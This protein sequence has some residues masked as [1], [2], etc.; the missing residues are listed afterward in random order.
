MRPRFLNSRLLLHRQIL[1]LYVTRRITDTF[2]RDIMYCCVQRCIMAAYETINQM[3]ILR[4]RQ[5]IHNWWHNSHCMTLPS[6]LDISCLQFPDVFAAL[7]VMLTFQTLDERGKQDVHLPESLDVDQIISQ[8]YELL[9]EVGGQM[10]PI[11]ARYRDSLRRME[12][13]LKTV[14][15]GR[16]KFLERGPLPTT[17]PAEE[18]GRAEYSTNSFPASTDG[19]Y[20]DSFQQMGQIPVGFGDDFEEIENLFYSTGW[21]GQGN[22]WNEMAQ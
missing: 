14:S 5:L 6:C 12:A 11:A 15:A 19:D 17:L 20:G 3:R 16:A 1:L 9:E 13:K 4:Q 18:Q 10:H 2:Q 21:Y 8:G 22:E 7:G